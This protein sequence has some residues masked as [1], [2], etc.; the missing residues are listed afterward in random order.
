MDC[1]GLGGGLAVSSSTRSRIR[2]VLTSGSS[3]R[4]DRHGA[5]REYGAWLRAHADRRRY[6]SRRHPAP[7]QVSVLTTVFDTPPHLLRA[8]AASV[9]GQTAHEFEWVVLDNGS[10]SPE[11]VGAI[12]EFTADPRVH[13]H[14][15][16]RNVGIIGGMRVCLEAAGGEYVAP[17]DADDVLVPDALEVL[18]D[19]I[20]SH[21]RPRFLY[22]DED[23][24]VDDVPRAP[25]LRPDWDPVLN[26]CTSYAFHL[27][28][29]HRDEALKLGVYTDPGAE[30]CHDWDTISRFAEVGHQ[31]VHVSEVL[32]HWRTHRS[33]STNRAQPV[34][35]SL[36]SQR[37]LLERLLAER[38]LVDLFELVPFPLFRGAPEWW[39]RRRRTRPDSLAA[40]RVTA[41]P[42]GAVL[43]LATFAERA[44]Y[45]FK[46]LEALP[47]HAESP[48]ARLK[49]AAE[50]LSSRFIVVCS[51]DVEPEG[52]E[53][54]W[55]ATGLAELHPD[56]ALVAGRIL[57]PDRLVLAGQEILGFDGL[58]GCPERGRAELDPGYFG[59]ALK[60]RSV[61]AVHSSFFVA[62]TDFFI[63]A[64]RSLPAK[65][66]FAFLGVWL[67]AKAM[68][69]GR[70]VAF[71][72]LVQAVARSGFEAR[73]EATREEE[74]EFF[75]SYGHLLPDVRW[76][77]PHFER[78]IEAA[79]QLRGV[80]A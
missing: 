27:C 70:I 74:A 19:E 54:P 64:L 63:D 38:G 37:H 48:L 26:L 16:E 28:A 47:V 41:D 21:G 66:S 29:F 23:I 78:S 18:A 62:R 39:L 22:S 10:T 73:Q 12:S 7:G 44:K 3:L 5:E 56:V 17:F 69:Q 52:D 57:N 55:E 20:T 1:S 51:D 32:Y 50:R 76:Y 33:S 13:Y 77:S 8:A 61:S 60:Q 6:R 11:V 75:G 79:Y 30:W 9:L 40:V 43:S 68:E 15:V 35:D 4:A 71:S 34:E 46:G 42:E 80:P 14:R 65:A 72:P 58:A 31:P 36:A 67:G 49:D 53:W 25:Y 24:L 45:P 2:S 59:L